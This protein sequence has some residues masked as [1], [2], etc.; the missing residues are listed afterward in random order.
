MRIEFS[1]MDIYGYRDEG[2]FLQI[3]IRPDFGARLRAYSTLRTPGDTTGPD[4]LHPNAWP[5]TGFNVK[6][7]M[8]PINRMQGTKINN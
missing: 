4:R 8:P 7:E 3:R 5:M 2:F 6:H 1:Q